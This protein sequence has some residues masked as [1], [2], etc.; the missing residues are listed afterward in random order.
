MKKIFLLSTLILIGT[1]PLNGMKPEPSVI[2]TVNPGSSTMASMQDYM[3]MLPKEIKEYIVLILTQSK[4]LEEAIH[5]IRSLTQT[6]KKFNTIINNP[7]TT[8]TIIRFLAQKF[9]APT[10]YIAQQL[11]TAGSQQYVALSLQLMQALWQYNWDEAENLLKIGADVNFQTADTYP[12]I[13]GLS[14]GIKQQWLK[15]S[16]E[17]H[18]NKFQKVLEVQKG[19]II[20]RR[21]NGITTCI[22]NNAHGCIIGAGFSLVMYAIASNQFVILEWLTDH[23]ANL[24][25]TMNT[26]DTALLMAINMGKPSII[27]WLINN[28]ADINQQNKMNAAINP[29]ISNIVSGGSFAT[30]IKK[31]NHYYDT[32]LYSLLNHEKLRSIIIPALNGPGATPIIRLLRQGS[33]FTQEE[34]NDLFMLLIIKGANLNLQDGDGN[35]ALRLLVFTNGHA[36]LMKLLLDHGADPTIK[37]K[38]DMNA[39]D[40][41]LF[42]GTSE[43]DPERE[44]KIQLLE[45]AMKKYSPSH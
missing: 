29:K 32:T 43:N 7:I 20:S 25:L 28:G 33:Q 3:D 8:R 18:K 15:I 23:N 26:G 2:K 35:T 44:E 17:I 36:N 45:D 11:N 24:N 38:D 9:N 16:P 40:R 34:F 10:E 27:E 22:L 13:C 39:L 30:D 42:E 1:N 37:D 41:M 6:N 21:V 31:L 4:R 12:A 5:T 19:K 14:E